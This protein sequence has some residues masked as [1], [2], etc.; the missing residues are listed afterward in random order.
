[1]LA[2][3]ELGIAGVVVKLYEPYGGRSRID[4][5]PLQAAAFLGV[6]L[7]S[8]VVSLKTNIYPNIL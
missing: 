4:S 5:R 2:F 8:V 1:M 6:C 7:R 3:E